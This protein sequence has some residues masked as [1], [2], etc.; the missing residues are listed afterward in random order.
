MGTICKYSTLSLL[1]LGISLLGLIAT[2]TYGSISNYCCDSKSPT[3]EPDH[4]L[5]LLAQ[6]PEGARVYRL[7]GPKTVVPIVFVVTKQ[8]N[9]AIR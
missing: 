4:Q 5:I 3:I 9:T 6:T 1:V 8:G 2:M 7:D